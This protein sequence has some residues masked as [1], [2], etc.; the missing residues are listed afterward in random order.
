MMNI[1][2]LVIALFLLFS[3]QQGERS[4]LIDNPTNKPVTILFKNEEPLLIEPN[5]K[6]EI[7][8]KYGKRILSIDAGPPQKIHLK[9]S[10]QYLLNPTLSYY[11]IHRV[12]YFENSRGKERYRNQYGE[13]TSRIQHPNF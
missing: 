12:P 5:T 11:Y 13:T 7:V 10:E 6:K 3:C 1:S 2:T 4:L 9:P 8:T